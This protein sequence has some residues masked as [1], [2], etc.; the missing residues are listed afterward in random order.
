MKHSWASRWLNL[1]RQSLGSPP[2]P[3]RRY[4]SSRC[5][6]AARSAARPGR[7][8][9]GPAATTRGAGLQAAQRD[10]ARGTVLPGVTAV[11]RRSTA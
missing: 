8:R 5:W 6:P 9:N 7:L 2:P 10:V 3:P 1:L 4:F 11:R